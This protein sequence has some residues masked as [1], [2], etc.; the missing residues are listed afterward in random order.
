MITIPYRV[1]RFL[2]NLLVTAVAFAMLAALVLVLWALWL[3]RF[4]VYT[5]AGAVLDFSISQDMTP[6]QVAVPPAPG[7]NVDIYYNEGTDAIGPVDTELKQLMGVS[8]SAEQ[9]VA[10][11]PGITQQIQKLPTGTAVMLDMKNIRG[12]FY[13][14]SSIGR[15]S[16]KINTAELEA[17]I[18]TLRSKGYYLIAHI[19][20]FRDYWYGLSHVSHGLYNLNRYSLWMDSDRCYWLNPASDGALN[21]LR[22]ILFEL[23]TLGFQEVVFYDFRFPDTDKIYFDGDKDQA[24][25]AAANLLVKACASDTFAVSFQ[26]T[27]ASFPLPQGRSRLYLTGVAAV[28]V[29]GYAE[30]TG[31]E[32]PEKRLV[33]MTELRDTRF[34]DYGVLR[35]VVTEE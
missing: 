23:R 19:P 20:A 14:N 29:A 25:A 24:L 30:Q 33:F 5:R 18:S 7:P 1:R 35:P 17:M 9:L 28:D 15:V 27:D 11:I 10:D 4:L 16:A 32:D 2:R 6:G 13:Y 31:L 21:Y 3:N 34:E 8:V 22:E 26:S 12:E